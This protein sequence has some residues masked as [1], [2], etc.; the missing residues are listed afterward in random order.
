MITMTFLNSIHTYSL[1]RLRYIHRWLW[2]ENMW[3]WENECPTSQYPPCHLNRLSIRSIKVSCHA[4]ESS[5]D[6][7]PEVRYSCG[8]RHNPIPFRVG[9]YYGSNLTGS[10]LVRTALGD[11]PSLKACHCSSASVPPAHTPRTL[12]SPTH[13]LLAQHDNI[14]GGNQAQDASRTTWRKVCKESL[15]CQFGPTHGICALLQVVS[16]RD[17]TVLLQIPSTQSSVLHL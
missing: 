14:D 5:F 17:Y 8:R 2:H 10:T 7:T 9:W 15:I 3:W 13:K 16:L 1:D 4:E 11:T 12:G 6:K